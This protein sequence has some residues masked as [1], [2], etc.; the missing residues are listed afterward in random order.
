[1]RFLLKYPSRSRPALWHARIAEWTSLAS[2][3]HSLLW[4]CSFDVDDATMPQAKVLP[5]LQQELPKV[6]RFVPPATLEA[7]AFWGHNH[8]KVEAINADLEQFKAVPWEILICISDDMSC[9]LTDWDETIAA[10]MLAAF[11]DLNGA[12]WYPDGFQKEQRTCTFSIM[13]RPVYDELG[14]IYEASFNSVYCDNWFTEQMQASHRLK[15]I[16]KLLVRHEWANK[17]ALMHR[18][19]SRELYDRDRATYARLKAARQ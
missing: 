8:S 11:P 15:F 17:D 10:D 13:G 2:G 19:E 18:N 9:K 7:H 4:V 16:D 1:M 12:L 5:L 3:R 14:N 6:R